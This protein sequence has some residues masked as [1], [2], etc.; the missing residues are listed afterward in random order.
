MYTD[1]QTT[2]FS[3][4]GNKVPILQQLVESTWRNSCAIIENV[5]ILRMT[6]NSPNCFLGFRD[7]KKCS[8]VQ[9]RW[10][11]PFLPSF[12]THITH[13]H[14]WR[15][16]AIYSICIGLGWRCVYFW[17][18]QNCFEDSNFNRFKK[19]IINSLFI[20]IS[21]YKLPFFYLCNSQ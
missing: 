21:L 2:T 17:N 16:T 18:L 14:I 4:K 15:S 1:K 11:E 20:F 5:T 8:Q 13:T 19:K 9:Q 6:L 3:P 12:L 10:K 7:N